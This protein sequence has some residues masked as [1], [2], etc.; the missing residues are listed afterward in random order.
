MSEN[1]AFRADS[2]SAPR[3]GD[4]VGPRTDSSALTA[5]DSKALYEKRTVVD[6]NAGEITVLRPI[7]ANGSPD[8]KR[9]E[10]FFAEVGIVWRGQPKKIGFEIEASRLSEACEK[11]QDRANEVAA[12]FLEKAESAAMR[13]YLTGQAQGA[14][15]Q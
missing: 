5:F 3:S 9:Q 14:R 13:A 6:V 8:L 1:S 4:E 2:S 15:V 10:R 11:Y 7:E 12:E